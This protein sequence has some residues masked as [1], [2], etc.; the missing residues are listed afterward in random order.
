VAAPKQ[1]VCLEI[2]KPKNPTLTEE[3]NLLYCGYN[4]K[5]G[6]ILTAAGLD[7][8][9]PNFFSLLY[10]GKILIKKVVGWKN[11]NSAQVI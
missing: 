3:T 2:E 10:K 11:R 4:D 5:H 1:I 8:K 7:V 9:V 6:T